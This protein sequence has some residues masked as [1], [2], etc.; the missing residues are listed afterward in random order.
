MKIKKLLFVLVAALLLL[1]AASCGGDD[2]YTED[3]E[4]GYT[5][6]IDDEVD[7]EE[8]DE[9][10]TDEVDEEETDDEETEED[11][12]EE[13]TGPI[14][15]TACGI[16]LGDFFAEEGESGSGPEVS[17][18]DEETILVTYQVN[19]DE[20]SDPVEADVSG[21]LAGLQ[22]DTQAQEEIWDYFIHFMPA[23]QRETI[24]EF[25]IFTDGTD[26]VLAAVDQLGPDAWTLE[27]DIADAGD[28]AQ[29]TYS[30]LHEFAHIFTLASTQFTTGGGACATYQTDE[31]CT[32]EDS[33][34]NL[35][36]QQF[37]TDIYPE[38]EV[39]YADDTIEDFYEQYSD[40]FVTDYA[41][42]DPD[43]DIAEAWLYFIISPQP[44]G[45]TIA[46]QK[47]LFFYDFPEMVELREQIHN[48]L[49]AS[50]MD[51]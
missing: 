37:W 29:L 1:S 5:E 42:T 47:I 48:N 31:N 17:E 2:Y 38:W 35:F 15:E 41:A 32:T 6:A 3:Y 24:A 8:V 14:D 36:Y 51:Q 19:G 4:E 50:L 27:I 16:F 7:E 49:C 25:I 23:E 18:Q 28:K 12:T 13:P 34:L 46:E 26:N 21:E 45:D 43:E 20:I 33:Y 44:A 10:A 39:A 30:L 9:E 11:S 40:Q 22:Q